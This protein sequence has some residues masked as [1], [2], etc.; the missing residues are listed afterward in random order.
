M[1]GQTPMSAKGV[2]IPKQLACRWGVTTQGPPPIY[3]PPG[4]NTQAFKNM[5]QCSESFAVPPR[6]AESSNICSTRIPV[7]YI[8]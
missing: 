7:T 8:S 3:S 4:L 2:E 6:E 5:F 1:L